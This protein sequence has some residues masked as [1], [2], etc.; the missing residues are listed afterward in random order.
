MTTFK[1]KIIYSVAAVLIAVGI[2][3][4]GLSFGLGKSSVP[5]PITQNQT[6]TNSKQVTLLIDNGK[7]VKSYKDIILN[8]TDNVFTILQKVTTTNNIKLDYNPAASSAWGV[9]IKQ[10]GDKVNG[11][12][13]K[14]WQYWVSGEQPQIAA[15]K[16][17]LKGGEIVWWTFRESSF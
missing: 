15:D 8:Q 1:S 11:Q 12:N 9:F 2:F 4:L 13:Q 5:T 10:I 17:E 16:Y 14:Y 7:D 6:E 3:L